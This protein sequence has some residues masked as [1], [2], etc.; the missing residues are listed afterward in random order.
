[1]IPKLALA[2]AL[3]TPLLA[4]DQNYFSTTVYPALQKANCHG[5]HNPDGVAAGTRLHFPD[6][7]ASPAAIENFGL[8]L[9][10]L[11]DP[12][13]PA[14]S[15]LLN[16]PTRR[17]AHAGGKRI[18][19]GSPEETF[20]RAWVDYLATTKAEAK[21]E[22]ESAATPVGPVLRRLTHAQYNNTIRDLLG[23][24]GNLSNQ[25]PPEDFINGFTNQYQ[26]Q[27]ISPLLAE[28]YSAAAEK[29]AQNAFRG[30]DTHNLIPCK[31]ADAG[32]PEKFVRAFGQ[33]A[34]RRPLQKE[35]VDRY[36]R[37]FRS[38][39][40]LQAGAQIVVEAMLQSPSF[41]L[42]TDKSQSQGY[43]RASRLSYFLWNTM[44]DAALF[45]SAASGELDTPQGVETAARRMLKDPKARESVDDFIAQWL[46][47]DRLLNTIKDRGTF[48]QYGPE[49]ALAMTE[50]AR[51][52]VSDLVWN[53][54]DFT[55][56]Y[57]ADYAFLNSGLADLYKVKA[58][59]D[60]FGKV[61]LPPETERAGILGQGLF[62]GLTSKPTDTSPTA[63]GLFVREQFLCQEVPQ[64]PPGVSTNLPPLTKEKPQT[65]RERLAVHLSN[66]SC[67]SCHT[68]IDPIGFGLEKF[69][70]I[71][72]R[73]E[74]QKLTFRAGK[75]D[76]KD[77]KTE[78]VLLALDST[79]YIA[80]I[81]NSDFAS[82]RTLGNVL[83]ASEQ[84]QECI[85]KQLFRY[86]SGRKETPADR[87]IIRQ[88]LEDFRSSGFH[89]QDLMVSLIKSSLTTWGGPPGPRR[90]PS[91]GQRTDSNGQ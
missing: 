22:T 42:R 19:P 52:L 41:L 7:G 15:L 63:R 79:G 20:L 87:Q 28:A 61:T 54:G 47:F 86:E 31:Q 64:P 50:E 72:Q 62:L 90:A 38:Q 45:R 35:E 13:D 70:A 18:N 29:L 69:D 14:K 85:V 66:E 21:T 24:E 30:G 33:R 55:K 25:F 68:L 78:T 3:A 76:G 74:K 12:K 58:P 77:R 44:P 82:P 27:S 60:D 80:G 43:E 36:A 4:I 71:G 11:V 81:K 9:K 49:L 89:F 10:P 40:Q 39:K 91:P 84:C 67:A 1:M 6:D 5:C 17:V 59:P 57:S 88:S 73:R 48:P 83:A 53:N 2:L 8:S 65:N 34:F 37:L 75:E 26:S 56:I 32:C 46:R 16:K 23:D 51:R